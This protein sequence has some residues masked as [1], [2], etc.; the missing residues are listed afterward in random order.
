MKLRIRHNSIR[1]RLTQT[2]VAQLRDAG[3]V[4]E[5][6]EF[7]QGHRLTYRITAQGQA[8]TCEY[9]DGNIVLAVPKPM[10]DAWANSSQVGMESD[11]PLRLAIEKDFQCL[12]PA[13]PEENVDTF[14]NPKAC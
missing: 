4:E 1:L 6:I 2:E 8:L 9:Q 12:D 10:V 3:A 7:S 13:H 14:P 5:Y 11:G